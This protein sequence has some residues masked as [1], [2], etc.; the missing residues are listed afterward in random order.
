MRYGTERKEFLGLMKTSLVPA[1]LEKL[2]D[3]RYMCFCTNIE[4]CDALGG[5]YSIHSK[6]KGNEDIV[7]KFNNLETNKIF[8]VFKGIEGMNFNQIESGLFVVLEGSERR[9]F[10]KFGRL[11]R[12]EHPEIYILYY[13]DTRDEEFLKNAIEGIDKNYIKELNYDE[14]T[15]KH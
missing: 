14:F 10:Q 6:K 4:Q 13:K 5:E 2:E 1:I 11:L 15:S 3:K 8:V 9:M 7:E 12:A